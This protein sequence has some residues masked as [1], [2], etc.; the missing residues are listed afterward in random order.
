MKTRVL[1]E[2]FSIGQGKT[3]NSRQLFAVLTDEVRAKEAAKEYR[4]KVSKIH[5]VF[6]DDQWHRYYIRPLHLNVG[7]GIEL[8]PYTQLP[9]EI[10]GDDPSSVANAQSEL[11]SVESRYVELLRELGVQGHSGAIAEIRALRKEAKPNQNAD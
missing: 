11:A 2:V 6:I 4:A 1:F 9:Q 3:Y 5:A 7:F 10:A 8:P